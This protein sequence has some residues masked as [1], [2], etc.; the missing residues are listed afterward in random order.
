MV[1]CRIELEHEALL[2]V[3]EKK[4]VGLL[5]LKLFVYKLPVLEH[6]QDL[7]KNLF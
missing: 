5:P 3:V 2:Q 6:I 1:R 7:P 4:E